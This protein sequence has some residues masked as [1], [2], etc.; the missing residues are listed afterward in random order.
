MTYKLAIQSTVSIQL[1][2]GHWVGHKDDPVGVKAQGKNDPQSG[3]FFQVPVLQIPNPPKVQIGDSKCS[4]DPV[5]SGKWGG[6][7]G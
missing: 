7:Q 5:R 4:I 6:V 2:V 3:F 1:G